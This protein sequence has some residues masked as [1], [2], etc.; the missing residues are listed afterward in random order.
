[1]E[2]SSIPKYHKNE[3][4]GLEQK[5]LVNGG[6]PWVWN[7]TLFILKSRFEMHKSQNQNGTREW[8]RSVKPDSTIC[9]IFLLNVSPLCFE[10]WGHDHQWEIPEACKLREVLGTLISKIWLKFL[11]F[12]WNL[13]STDFWKSTKVWATSNIYF[14]GKNQIYLEWS[15]MKI[16]KYW[17]PL[18][19]IIGDGTYPKHRYR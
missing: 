17:W 11:I 4:S 2:K 7:G 19:D 3:W 15:S 14:N 9:Q 18:W 10:V 13:F 6:D 1:M 8:E 12:V 5:N 16:T